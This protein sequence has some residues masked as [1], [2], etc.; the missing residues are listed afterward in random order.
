MKQVLNTLTLPESG[1]SVAVENFNRKKIR[2]MINPLPLN[3]IS[4]ALQE[5]GNSEKHE[6]LNVTSS[7]WV[8][9]EENVINLET[10]KKTSRIT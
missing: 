5:G 8:I 7:L 3:S 4:I 1:I 2:D 6:N 9:A 10:Q